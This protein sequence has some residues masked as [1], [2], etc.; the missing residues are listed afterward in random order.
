MAGNQQLALNRE[1][2]DVLDDLTHGL[3]DELPAP[4]PQ[5]AGWQAQMQSV[6]DVQALLEQML[7]EGKRLEDVKA[8]LLALSAAEDTA[9]I[10]GLT[11]AAFIA[12]ALGD[13]SGDTA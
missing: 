10:E 6:T 7:A 5:R 3:D 4:P 13:L 12:R 1:Q 11:E 8:A 9:L 2:G